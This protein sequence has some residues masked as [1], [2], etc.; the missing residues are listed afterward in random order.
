[1][2]ETEPAASASAALVRE[3]SRVQRLHEERTGNPILAGA[4]ERVASWQARRLAMTYADLAADPRYAAAVAFFQ[5]D[6]YGPGDFSRRDADLARVVPLMVKVLPDRVIATVAQAMEL[7]ALSQELDRVL[8]ARLPRADGHFSVPE[9]C[10]A[11][12]RAANFPLRRRQIKLIVD[13]GTA[14]DAHVGKPLIRT[15]L[16]MMRQPARMAGMSGLQDFL[17]RGFSAFRAMRGAGE[18]LR[19]IETRE[20]QILEAIVGG[21][22]DPFADPLLFR[23]AAEAANPAAP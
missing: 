9:Y 18:F 14:L 11:Y 23:K 20:V 17:E 7:N 1:M 22:T 6:L 15:A 13:I 5:N 12:R 16:A 10:R 8:L 19:T 3:L 4:L 21:S 2:A